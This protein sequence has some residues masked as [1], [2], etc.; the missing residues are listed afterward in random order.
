M[1]RQRPWARILKDTA[2]PGVWF[3]DYLDLAC[4]QFP[5]WSRH[6]SLVLYRCTKRLV[7][8]L[9]EAMRRLLIET[10]RRRRA[11]RH[12]GAVEKVNLQDSEIEIVAP[13]ADHEVIAVH[14]AIDDLGLDEARKAEIVKLRYFVG[15]EFSEIAD[16]TG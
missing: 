1:S 9:T 5:L 4:V 6:S 8:H 13:A 2:A 10:A 3:E 7:P 14:D 15:L 11:L 12:R 16:L